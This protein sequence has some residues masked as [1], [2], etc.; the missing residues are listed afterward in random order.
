MQV[1]VKQKMPEWMAQA[2]SVAATC[3]ELV[4]SLIAVYVHGSAALGGFG[5]SSDLDVLVVADALSDWRSLAL[6]LMTQENP[7]PLE[8]SV[9][10]ARD[11]ACPAPP[12]PYLLH[13]NTIER[14]F[15]ADDGTGDPDLIAHYAITRAA[16]VAVLGPP[17]ASV[18]GPV[19]RDDL[20]DYLRDELQWGLDH[21][22]Q[23]YAVL[24]GCRAAAY[25]RDS[26]L[27]SKVDGA[28]WWLRHVRDDAVVREALA[29]QQAG[30][31]AGPSSHIARALVAECLRTLQVD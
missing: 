24:N 5:P 20:M 10:A 23:R 25:A 26:V 2:E 14:R 29:D 15:I 21:A 28:R 1:E 27:L 30:R 9:V 6:R 7:H 31:N 4:P 17:P 13:V 18:V 12:W 8:L 16:G 22:D 3:G 11:A 19:P